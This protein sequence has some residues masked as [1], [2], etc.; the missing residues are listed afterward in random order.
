MYYSRYCITCCF[1][2]SLETSLFGPLET[3]FW[4]SFSLPWLAELPT[5]TFSP[6][7]SKGPGN[8]PPASGWGTLVTVPPCPHGSLLEASRGLSF[9]F[10]SCTSLGSRVFFV[11]FNRSKRKATDHGQKPHLSS[12]VWGTWQKPTPYLRPDPGLG[13]SWM[14]SQLLELPLIS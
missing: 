7:Y 12:S 6:H 5:V 11:S 14:Y 4:P 9:P 2:F 13:G 3:P 1:S 8:P 10:H